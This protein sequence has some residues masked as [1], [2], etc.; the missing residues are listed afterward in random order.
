[1]IERQCQ[2]LVEFIQPKHT[3]DLLVGHEAAKQRLREDARWV[4]AGQLDAAADGLSD[5]RARG[6]R[7]D[8]SRRMLCRLDRHPLCNAAK[9]S[10]EI[11]RRTEGNL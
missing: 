10:L 3:L 5:L 7:Q 11:R 9:F 2:G 1:M 4:S 8:V 6:N